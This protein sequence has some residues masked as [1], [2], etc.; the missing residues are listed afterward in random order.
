MPPAPAIYH[1]VDQPLLE[2]PVL[3]VGETSF[4]FENKT[5]GRANQNPNVGIEVGRGLGRRD[6]DPP[7]GYQCENGKQ[8]AR[9]CDNIHG[10]TPQTVQVQRIRSILSLSRFLRRYRRRTARDS[11]TGHTSDPFRRCESKNAPEITMMTKASTTEI[12]AASCKIVA[13]NA[14]LYMYKVGV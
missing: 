4:T 6:Q 10:A 3:L 7:Y 2:R 12:A 5:N 13:E 14:S 9:Q 11:G 1:R 8:A